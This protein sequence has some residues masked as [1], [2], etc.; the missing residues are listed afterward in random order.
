MKQ[1]IGFALYADGATL[2]N[3]WST[4][5]DCEAKL[6]FLKKVNPNTRIVKVTI[7]DLKVKE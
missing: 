5:K 2:G 7:E 1:T 3:W 4:K 6:V